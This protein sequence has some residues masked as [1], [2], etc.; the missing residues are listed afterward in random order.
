MCVSF[1]RYH[2]L[3]AHCFDINDVYH[4]WVSHRHVNPTERPPMQKYHVRRPAQTNIAKHTTRVGPRLK[5][6][7]QMPPAANLRSFTLAAPFGEP[8]IEDEGLR[9]KLDRSFDFSVPSF[10]SVPMII[11]AMRRS[12][13]T[14]HSMTSSADIL[15]SP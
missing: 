14:L 12:D 11:F 4:P 2:L 7:N 15:L 10:R 8:I 1:R 6:H 5:R 13:Q 3:V 9:C